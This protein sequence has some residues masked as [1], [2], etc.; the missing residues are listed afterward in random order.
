VEQEKQTSLSV[1]AKLDSDAKG[2]RKGKGT[3]DEVLNVRK[4]IRSVSKGKGSVAL[5]R[6]VNSKGVRGKRGG[7][8]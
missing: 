8:R 7:K 1:L 4:A 5:A 6:G 2:A 3:G